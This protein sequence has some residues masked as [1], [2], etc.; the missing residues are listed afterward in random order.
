MNIDAL[1]VLW[2]A[3]KPQLLWTN[4]DKPLGLGPFTFAN[5]PEW[6]GTSPQQKEWIHTDSDPDRCL[7]YRMF[8]SN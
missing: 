7:V 6:P 2:G 8:G 5:M 1:I 3:G 4:L